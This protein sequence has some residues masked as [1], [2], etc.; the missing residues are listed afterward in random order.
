MKK[1]KIIITA[2]I[3]VGFLVIFTGYVIWS[4]KKADYYAKVSRETNDRQIKT[5]D[6]EKSIELWPKESNIITLADLYIASG[7]SDLAEQIMVGRGETD[8]LNKLGDL[9][10][11]E[12][13]SEKAE[14]A[15][16]KANNK[17]VN[18]ESLK[19]LVLTQLKK[20]NRG[21]AENYLEQLYNID[22]DSASCYASF[23]YLNNFDIAKK[24]FTKAKACN[25]FDLNKYFS[26]YNSSQNP[27]YLRLEASNIYFQNNYLQLALKDIL[28]LEKEKENY[29]DAYILGF[30]IYEKLGD[31]AKENRQKLK[32]IQ[33]DPAYSL[34]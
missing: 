23:T 16:V 28:A 10:L 25:L 4:Y 12:N 26:R 11:S 5:E 34:N 1:K 32:V 22:Q 24:Y 18:S 17:K 8:I 9:Y 7:R 2:L 15:F 31:K 29:R 14:K 30:K 20:G 33:I 27:F 21:G 3:L 6:L 19:G 13:Q